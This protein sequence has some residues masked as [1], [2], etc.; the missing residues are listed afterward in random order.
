ME[1]I[2]TLFP[3]FELLTISFANS[4]ELTDINT[5]ISSAND[6]V[7]D[8]LSKY[9]PT[10][11][12]LQ[13]KLN[14]AKGQIPCLECIRYFEE[15][16]P[17]SMVFGTQ[18]IVAPVPMP[19]SLVVSMCR[20]RLAFDSNVASVFGFPASR[21]LLPTVSEGDFNSN[22]DVPRFIA[23]S[24]IH[25]PLRIPG[26]ANPIE[27]KDMKPEAIDLFEEIKNDRPRKRKKYL[28]DMVEHLDKHL[29]GFYLDGRTPKFNVNKPLLY[30]TLSTAYRFIVVSEHFSISKLTNFL[31]GLERHLPSGKQISTF[32]TWYDKQLGIESDQEDAPKTERHLRIVKQSVKKEKS[33][34]DKTEK[35]QREK[36]EEPD[37]GILEEPVL[38]RILVKCRGTL[39]ERAAGLGGVNTISDVDGVENF[40]MLEYFQ[41]EK[42]EILEVEG[43]EKSFTWF[44]RPY[45]WDFIVIIRT[46]YVSDLLKKI[47][48]WRSN[49]PD[50]VDVVTMPLLS[51]DEKARDRVP[52]KIG[53]YRKQDK[54]INKH[55]I[56]QYIKYLKQGFDDLENIQSKISQHYLG[57]PGA[58]G[59]EFDG[60][61]FIIWNK[62]REEIGYAQNC[63]SQIE[64]HW[65]HLIHLRG[66]DSIRTRHP[67]TFRRMIEELSNCVNSLEEIEANNSLS[68]DNPEALKTIQTIFWN[69]NEILGTIRKVTAEFNDKTES[70]QAVSSAEHVVKVGETSGVVDMV[71]E[72]AGRVFW[73]Y[74][75]RP[76]E[77]RTSDYDS[78]WDGIVCSSSDVDFKINP[79]LRI[80]FLPSNIK[81]MGYDDLVILA[82]EAGHYTMAQVNVD[83]GNRGSDNNLFDSFVREVWKD[84]L[85]AVIN[86]LKDIAKI[87]SLTFEKLMNRYQII[88]MADEPLGHFEFLADILAL[89]SAGP[90]YL[91]A[92][93]VHGFARAA[94][95]NDSEIFRIY[96]PGKAAREQHAPLWIRSTILYKICAMLGWL[97]DDVFGV[98]KVY[99]DRI[100]PFFRKLVEINPELK[101]RYEK[102]DG[103]TYDF[104]MNDLD[105]IILAVSSHRHLGMNRIWPEHYLLR[106]LNSNPGEEWLNRFVI[107]LVERDEYFLFYPITIKHKVQKEKP[108]NRK[109]I[110]F[111]AE[112][113]EEESLEKLRKRLSDK[114]D[115]DKADGGDEDEESDEGMIYDEDFKFPESGV[116][117]INVDS[118][119]EESEKN[120]DD[121]L[122]TGKIPEKGGGKILP[123]RTETVHEPKIDFS[124]IEFKKSDVSK[125]N[126][127]CTYIAEKMTGN[128]ITE[129]Q[130]QNM[131]EVVLDAPIKYIL[132]GSY[133]MTP[134]LL[135]QYINRFRAIHA[136]YYSEGDSSNEKMKAW[137]EEN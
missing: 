35:S 73:Y 65:Y 135:P 56:P 38:F 50:V 95:Y 5:I 121:F 53:H 99:E 72:A 7:V 96:T 103:S 12:S 48:K 115:K 37:P 22:S 108:I 83:R 131:G 104:V 39:W 29:S 101:N 110:K 43:A 89:L 133:H 86:Q 130:P 68:T 77:I 125:V 40:G 11:I 134:D 85:S 127:Y 112:L 24:F 61:L 90:A 42:F 45:F 23:Y 105:K 30:L 123:F 32:V 84:Y 44:P 14:S 71:A 8:F 78:K 62:L 113:K 129:E 136:I 70:L 41:G 88:E 124:K 118:L 4:I 67:S 21:I 57:L 25:R 111:D 55:F 18:D 122:I 132:A 10:K 79:N 137:I 52:I 15:S 109:K 36:T 17:Y 128:K 49:R 6:N 54:Y 66:L 47:V 75:F 69:L 64:N 126:K 20:K 82:H 107:W 98:K 46:A 33:G 80:L 1:K 60:S 117:G 87:S 59:G 116:A 119:A 74:S 34:Q 100:M 97:D 106:F 28:L 13:G 9:C 120:V 91:H 114:L 92:L 58:A 19:N 3:N 102:R 93:L 2:L 27:K 81:S 31:L 16:E 76:F 63:V 94:T 26:P 51:T